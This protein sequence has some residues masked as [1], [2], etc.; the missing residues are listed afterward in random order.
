[1]KKYT[2]CSVSLWRWI[3]RFSPNWFTAVLRVL[4]HIW[5]QFWEMK[6][7]LHYV[8]LWLKKLRDFLSFLVFIYV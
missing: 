8:K 4:N 6:I 5:I 1:M 2:K 7:W 3:Y